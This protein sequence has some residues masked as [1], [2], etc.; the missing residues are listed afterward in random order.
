M[1]ETSPGLLRLNI[2]SIAGASLAL[3]SLLL[4]WFSVVIQFN[5]GQ[6][7]PLR[8]ILMSQWYYGPIGL[9]LFLF[10]LGTFVSFGSPS[11]GTL[12]LSAVAILF[13]R[14]SNPDQRW[15]DL[16]IRY[17]G[18]QSI[19]LEIGILIGTLSAVLVL[20]SFVFRLS[21]DI[22]F[23]RARAYRLVTFTAHMPLVEGCGAKAV[24][25]S[26][27]VGFVSLS[28]AM[29]LVGA[30][31]GMLSL[32]VPWVQAQSAG[33][34]ATPL[35]DFITGAQTLGTSPVMAVGAFL[36]LVGS[37]LAIV[38][39]S[40][41][42]V[43]LVG[44]GVFAWDFSQLPHSGSYP[45]VGA[46]E[47][48]HGFFLGLTSTVLVA[49]SPIIL[50]FLRRRRRVRSPKSIHQVWQREPPPIESSSGGGHGSFLNVLGLV[51][52]TLGFI[53]ILVPWV[54]SYDSVLVQDMNPMQLLIGGG[55]D[56]LLIYSSLFIIGT[57][58]ALITPAG[59]L[60]Q[61][62]SA[63]GFLTSVVQPIDAE[64]ARL[65][66]PLACGIGPF[67]GLLSGLIVLRSFWFPIWTR[68]RSGFAHTSQYLFVVSAVTRATGQPFVSRGRFAVMI[69]DW[70]W[71]ISGARM[72]VA[73][74]LGAFLGIVACGMMWS[75]LYSPSDY[76][77]TDILGF[78]GA[79]DTSTGSIYLLFLLFFCGS[80]IALLS[81][82][83]CTLQLAGL[84]GFVLTSGVL[85][86]FVWTGDAGWGFGIGVISFLM[87][88]GSF[89]QPW[90]PGNSGMKH[91]LASRLFAWG[92][93]PAFSDALPA[94]GAI[95]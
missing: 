70:R 46:I 40:G 44:L 14:L 13:L 15:I 12:Q 86:G 34:P 56:D 28:S 26:E 62:I 9:S 95:K 29:C 89:F 18:R 22:R 10:L 33:H 61:V 4:P 37:L 30:L 82:L 92:P 43:Q 87:V 93:H 78:R 58:I 19:H 20:L 3:A 7:Q 59:G 2:L 54:M 77:A 11:G 24:K 17:W 49:F 66:A 55:P 63:F 74:L 73:C 53:A 80:M 35:G 76:L 1:E 85:R 68:L 90:G 57:V 21:L 51:G 47:L 88:A 81:S 64:W 75:S 71:C 5:P 50:L 94:A 39:A 32:A 42:L 23:A 91:T 72:N 65:H 83:G 6:P 45:W 84:V 27:P 38:S 52:A 25:N 67:L 69:H 41:C 48:A 36:F 8:Y 16:G 79:S 31:L 60:V